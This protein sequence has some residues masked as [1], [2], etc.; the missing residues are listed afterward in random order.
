MLTPASPEFVALCQSQIVLLAEGLNAA[1]S[2][3]YLTESID[4]TVEADLVPIAAYPEAAVSW[5]KEKILRL[6]SG[7]QASRAAQEPSF[8]R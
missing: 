6:L 2:V 8:D 3:V 5:E 7:V 1:L 4:A